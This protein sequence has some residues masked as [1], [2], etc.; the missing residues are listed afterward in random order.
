LAQERKWSALQ[1]A[2]AAGVERANASLAPVGV[3][4]GPAGE[5]SW[6]YKDKSYGAYRRVLLSGGSLAWLRLELLAEGSLRAGVRA[7][8]EDRASINATVERQAAGLTSEDA[9][10]LFS[11]CLQPTAALAA[12]QMRDSDER[13]SEAAWQ[14]IDAL[15]AAALKATNSALGQAG[16]QLTALAPAAWESGLRRHRMALAVEVNGN[17]VARM[18]IE[19]LPHEMEIAVGVREPQH[20]DLGRRRRIPTD[21]M[22]IHA[23][24]E[25]IASCAWPAIARF[26]DARRQA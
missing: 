7:H 18:H 26:Q 21:G 23:L 15:V 25:L 5:P 14:T 10:A 22:T 8:S 4:V 13:A 3:L 11:Q 12:A 17:E 16:A 20:A 24:A 9:F 1:P 2:I 6:S 19:R